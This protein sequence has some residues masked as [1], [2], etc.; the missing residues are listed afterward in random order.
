MI[1][2]QFGRPPKPREIHE[3]VTALRA[4]AGELRLQDQAPKPILLGRHLI[5]RGMKPGKQFGEILG[6]A[7]EA[8]LE[9]A[10][11][12]LDGAEQWLAK[13]LPE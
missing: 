4:R 6:D 8:Q 5:A 13:R 9:G 10:F 2:D 7:F 3:G 12:D 11:A 1:A